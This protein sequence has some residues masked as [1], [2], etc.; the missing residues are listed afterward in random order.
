P[1]A[2][3]GAGVN[4]QGYVANAF[5][6]VIFPAVAVNPFNLGALVYTLT[7]NE[8]YPSAAFSRVTRTTRPAN[9]VIA[10]LGQAPYDSP[11]EY[12][13]GRARWGAYAAGVGDNA[14]LYLATEYIREDCENPEYVTDI[15]SGRFP[16]LRE[17]NG[18]LEPSR[19]M[20]T[21]W[22]T[23]LIKIHAS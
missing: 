14:D 4:T 23:G 1:F 3:L 6:D 17:R 5:E 10:L 11:G 18:V 19:G 16:C 2:C 8:Y 12:V 15:F 20:E 22:G 13:P 9:I 7:G 21:N